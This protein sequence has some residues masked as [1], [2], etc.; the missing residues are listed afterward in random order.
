MDQLYQDHAAMRAFETLN[1]HQIL[2]QQEFI[3]L[4]QPPL[5]NPEQQQ[6][7]LE[8]VALSFIPSTKQN[9]PFRI[10]RQK[11]SK[12][13]KIE[14]SQE[15]KVF[16][17][18]TSYTLRQFFQK[19]FD[20]HESEER[21]WGLLACAA[22]SSLQKKLNQQKALF[23]VQD[24]FKTVR[25]II[26]D[27]ELQI[28]FRQSSVQHEL[29][30]F[31]ENKARHI[32][33]IDAFQ[34]YSLIGNSDQQNDFSNFRQYLTDYE[35]IQLNEPNCNSD[36][37]CG[38]GPDLDDFLDEYDS[39]SSVRSAN[40]YTILLLE[41]IERQS[42]ELEKNI[43]FHHFRDQ[44]QQLQVLMQSQQVSFPTEVTFTQQSF[45]IKD[46][47]S[48]QVSTKTQRKSQKYVTQRQFF[49]YIPP[50]TAEKFA[51]ILYAVQVVGKYIFKDLES[52]KNQQ[53]Y[54][55]FR[56]KISDMMDEIDNIISDKKFLQILRLSKIDQQI[57]FLKSVVGL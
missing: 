29:S 8:A 48:F 56:Q 36:Y 31:F 49:D 50:E 30:E 47:T 11:G 23:L 34:H 25:G 15:F 24:E 44:K 39:F 55:K 42:S 19:Q 37:G 20:R 21:S 6:K 1:R 26:F 18:Q 38:F 9:A 35:D 45:D 54:D 32:D 46:F 52:I 16:A 28:G 17:L 57:D 27:L 22:C 3:D 2:S 14:I 33:S 12:K 4:H 53:Q 7:T 10:S 40:L 5:T 51:E 13:V 41:N 43:Q